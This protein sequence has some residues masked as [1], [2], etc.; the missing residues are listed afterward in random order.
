MSSFERF[1]EGCWAL[2]KETVTRAKQDIPFTF[3]GHDVSGRHHLLVA[4]KYA[5][6]RQF[7][8]VLLF[9]YCQ[10][11]NIRMYAVASS[12]WLRLVSRPTGMS[13]EEFRK[14]GASGPSPSKAPD[15]IDALVLSARSEEFAHHAVLQVLN[16]DD[17]YRLVPIE[18]R[19]PTTLARGDAYFH[20]WIDDSPLLRLTDF[21]GVTAPQSAAQLM[22]PHLIKQFFQVI[23]IAS[24]D[25]EKFFNPSDN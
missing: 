12:A 24:P 2:T 9:G 4:P 6:K 8:R 5:D 13:N 16:T 18:G 25:V 15:R 21:S 3:I 17:D 1:V 20:Q 7:Y 19:D 11:Y 23:A 14:L 22:S 10:T